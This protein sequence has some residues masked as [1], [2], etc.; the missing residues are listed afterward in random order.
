MDLPLLQ[1]WPRNRWLTTWFDEEDWLPSKTRYSGLSV[2]E[3]EKNVYVEAALPGV[4]P[5]TI[6]VTFDK[7]IL[8]IRGS[9][10]KEEKDSK[11][12]YRKAS[13]SFAYRVDLPTT[14]EISQDPDV[15]YKDGMLSAT[16]IKSK[17]VPQTRKIAVKRD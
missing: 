16:F 6:D 11:R 5:D 17:E 12:Y 8:S 13:E 15:I 9:V 3:D 4:D 7:G 2:S 14:V 10:E 1:R